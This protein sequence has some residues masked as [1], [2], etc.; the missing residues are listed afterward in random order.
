MLNDT[1]TAST[2]FYKL[3]TMKKLNQKAAK[4]FNKLILKLND[5]GYLKLDASEGTFMPVVLEQLR[6]Q[7]AFGPMMVHIYSLA[8]YFNLN[9]DLV[10]D[11]DMTFAVHAQD[12]FLIWPLSY[13][14]QYRFQEGL[15]CDEKGVWK[16]N[17]QLQQ[18]HASFAN[19][20]LL[21]IQSQQ[22]L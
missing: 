21:N 2:V 4:V 15:F 9:G 20:W 18:D 11:P 16:V 17:R 12:P 22:D 14:D 8:H 5:Q 3:F 10:P 6:K 19:H 13:Q 7:V 1:R